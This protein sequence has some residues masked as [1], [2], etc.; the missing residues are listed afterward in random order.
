[1]SQVIAFVDAAGVLEETGGVFRYVLVFL[2]AMVPAVEPFVVIPV[3]IGLGLDPIATG[4][5]AFAG[6]V[7]AVGLIVGFQHRLVGWWRQRSGN[8]G[9]HSSGRAGRARRVW[10][11]YGLVGFSFVGP[12]LAGIHL[13]ALIA[14]T[15]D[16]RPHRVVIWLTVGLG[17]WTVALVAGS[18]AGLSVLGLS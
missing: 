8:D 6:S 17:A 13:A 11:R 10:E 12:I 18:V 16:G 3:G 1:M 2:L 15:V 4:F 5:A 7:T 9:T 14:I